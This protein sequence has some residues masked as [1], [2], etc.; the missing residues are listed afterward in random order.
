MK[1]KKGSTV[2]VVDNETGKETT[3]RILE[4]TP[5]SIVIEK[6]IKFDAKKVHFKELSSQRNKKLMYA[7]EEFIETHSGIYDLNDTAEFIYYERDGLL[8]LLK[9]WN[10]SK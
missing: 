3:G 9:E 8:K 2:T 6:L 5:D 10:E 7:L 1:V 4:Y